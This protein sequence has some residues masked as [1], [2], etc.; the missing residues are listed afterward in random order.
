MRALYERIGIRTGAH[1][2]YDT[3][4]AQSTG[5]RVRAEMTS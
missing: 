4:E 1:D 3:A 5:R 2:R